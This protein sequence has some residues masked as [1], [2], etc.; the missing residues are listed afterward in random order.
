MER[1]HTKAI[2]EEL[3]FVGRTPVGEVL[4]GLPWESPSTGAEEECVEEREAKVVS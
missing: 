1:T 2:L 3:Q 4:E